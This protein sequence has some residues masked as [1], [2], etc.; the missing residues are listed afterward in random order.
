M[1]QP[2]ELD[3]R[4][5]QHIALLLT[6]LA[7]LLD[8]EAEALVD[9]ESGEETRLTEQQIGRLREHRLTEQ[10]LMLLTGGGAIARH[11]EQLAKTLRGYVEAV[12]SPAEDDSAES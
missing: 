11:P 8:P 12:R 3:D 6:R 2:L 9:A 1:I 7:N 5:A 4:A 10:Q